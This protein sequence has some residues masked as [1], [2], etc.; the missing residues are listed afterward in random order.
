MRMADLRFR[1]G[2]LEG[3][4]RDLERAVELDRSQFNAQI[5]LAEIL[6]AQGQRDAASAR[7]EEALAFNPGFE[8]ALVLRER[9]RAP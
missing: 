5:V 8:R 6:A 4:K 3:V 2:D 9:L 7:V 1:M